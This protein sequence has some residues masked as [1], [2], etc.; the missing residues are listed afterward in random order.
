MA[1]KA[2]SF[3]EGLKSA[4]AEPEDP[5]KGEQASRFVE[6]GEGLEVIRASDAPT[7]Q[8]SAGKPKMVPI[9]DLL[10]DMLEEAED[11]EAK[12]AKAEGREP[13]PITLGDILNKEED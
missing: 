10:L 5:S 9:E 13:R 11:Q 3:D 8:T 4:E 6:T 7:N 1:R 2:V 12:L